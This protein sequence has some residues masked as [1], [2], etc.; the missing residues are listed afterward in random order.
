MPSWSIHLK[1]AS[2]L[3][4]EQKVDITITYDDSIIDDNRLKEIDEHFN[5]YG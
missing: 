4:K 2:E 5:H 1:V 3:N